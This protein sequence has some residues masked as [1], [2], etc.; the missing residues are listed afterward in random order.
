MK[1]V[2][3]SIRVDEKTFAE[4]GRLAKRFGYSRNH[5]IVFLLREAIN[6]REE[7]IATVFRPMK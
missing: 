4:V 7:I 1:H 2:R 3:F 5:A 6:R